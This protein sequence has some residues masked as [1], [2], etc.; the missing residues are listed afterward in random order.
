[1]TSV[2]H[3]HIDIGGEIEERKC[4]LDT[5]ATCRRAHCVLA[6]RTDMAAAI[7]ADVELY[8]HIVCSLQYSTQHI[9]R[10]TRICGV[11]AN[12]RFTSW[13]WQKSFIFVRTLSRFRA[14]TLSPYSTSTLT[15]P[16]SFSLS[17]SLRFLITL[18]LSVIAVVSGGIGSH[19]TNLLFA[20]LIDWT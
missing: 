3:I 6:S 15:H 19:S 11:Y 14:N 16:F 9:V 5:Y 12:T 7:V 1:M 10:L 20:H 2:A 17:P 13:H 8:F 4:W 18:V